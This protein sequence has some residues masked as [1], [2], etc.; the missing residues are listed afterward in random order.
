MARP[1]LANASDR[2]EPPGYWPKVAAHSQVSNNLQAAEHPLTGMQLNI[3]SVVKICSTAS[4]DQPTC[5]QSFSLVLGQ[6][7]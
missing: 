5:I 6:R 7:L 3:G 4:F 2:F 1:V